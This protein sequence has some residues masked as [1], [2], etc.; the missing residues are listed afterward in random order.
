MTN[1]CV[2]LQAAEVLEVC[3]SRRV[4]LLIND[5]VDVALAV[6][7]DGVH[8]G[9]VCCVQGFFKGCWGWWVRQMPFVA[10]WVVRAADKSHGRGG[11]SKS[12]R[13][14]ERQ[15]MVLGLPLPP[16]GRMTSQRRWCGA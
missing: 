2:P 15:R 10:C 3:R 9:Q 13:V 14:S 11:A 12:I 4:P 5:R 1:M 16:P 6:D 8:V 7:A